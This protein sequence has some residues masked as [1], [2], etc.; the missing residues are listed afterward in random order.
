MQEQEREREEGEGSSPF[1]S[2]ILYVTIG[3]IVAAMGYTAF[4]IMR[5]K[6]ATA[7]LR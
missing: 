6:K 3:A 4:K 2:T 7:K 5:S 1:S